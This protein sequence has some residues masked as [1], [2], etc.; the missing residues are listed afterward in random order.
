MHRIITLRF[1][2]L[3]GVD[4]DPAVCRFGQAGLFK[5]VEMQRFGQIP[6]QFIEA[7]ILSIVCTQDVQG[8]HTHIGECAMQEILC[9]L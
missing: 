5:V 7:I 4:M 2:R 1:C 3:F 6:G 9:R 8:R